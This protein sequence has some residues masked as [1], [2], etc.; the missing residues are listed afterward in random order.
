MYKRTFQDSLPSA[1]LLAMTN[2]A[3]G[4]TKGFDDFYQKNISVV[5]ERRIYKIEAEKKVL[6]EEEEEE[7]GV[8]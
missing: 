5:K 4:S 1:T 2:S 3:I 7:E 8:M 6:K